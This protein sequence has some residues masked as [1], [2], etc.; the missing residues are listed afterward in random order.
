MW[1][2]PLLTW[3][4]FQV[5]EEYNNPHTVDRIP[6][7]KLPLMWGQS[8]YILGCLMAEVWSPLV[9]GRAGWAGLHV[10]RTHAAT[11]CHLPWGICHLHPPR[12]LKDGLLVAFTCCAQPMR[13]L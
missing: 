11:L 13:C 1:V 7:G 5:D 4:L 6:M 8:L 12:P 2:G 3:L 10:Q 9:L